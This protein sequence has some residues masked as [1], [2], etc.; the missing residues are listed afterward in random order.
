[1]YTKN[2][3]IAEI[4]LEL[5]TLKHE[6]VTLILGDM[7]EKHIPYLFIR[8]GVLKDKILKLKEKQEDF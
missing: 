3:K 4:I 8:F 7:A 1:M 6:V 2:Q 5:D